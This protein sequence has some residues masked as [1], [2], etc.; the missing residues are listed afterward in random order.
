MNSATPP[1]GSPGKPPNFVPPAAVVRAAESVIMAM[2]I[3]DTVRP[4]VRQYQQR[5]LREGQWRIARQWIELKMD[6]Q[7][8]LD[9][10]N[11]YLLEPR[12][13]ALY[14]ARCNEARE[15]AKLTV[16]Q[17]GNCPLLEAET[18]LQ[19]AEGELVTAMVPVTG[20]NLDQVLLLP[21]EKYRQYIDLSL[22]L[23]AGAVDLDP[24]KRFGIPRTAPGNSSGQGNQVA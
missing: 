9:P 24:H 2:A 22:R 5:I 15:A 19:R 4:I 13:A 14:Y 8:I 11:D 18:L 7:V 3:V 12:D 10:K 1:P 6:D 17:V 16:E 20:I 23:V 21:I